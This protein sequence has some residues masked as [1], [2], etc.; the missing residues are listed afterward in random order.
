MD[1]IIER[2]DAWLVATSFAVAMLVSWGLGW[3]RGGRQAP[4]SGDDPGTKFTDA[5]L[6][7]LGLLLAFTFSMALSRYEQ[8][9]QAVVAESNAIG[10]FYT[11]ATLLKKPFRT[12]L[13]AVLDDYARHLL[14]AR[15]G[16]MLDPQQETEF[17]LEKFARMTE[18][19]RAALAEGTPVAVPLTN[20]L[21]DVTSNNASRQAAYRERLPGSIVLLLFLGSVVP[22]FLIGAKQGVSHKMHVAGSFSFIVLV[23]L[24]IYVTLDLNQPNRGLIRVSQYS[25]ER[26]VQ[27]MSMPSPDSK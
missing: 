11:C 22:A 16:T 19:A 10:D 27:S 4:E 20:T 7:L 14:E 24:V 13:Q 21:N 25:L 18:I 17:C 15:S 26:V 8:R 9:R 23:A 3:W 12:R 2:T 6:A 1:S 5:S